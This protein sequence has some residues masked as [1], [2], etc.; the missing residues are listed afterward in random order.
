MKKRILS[1]VLSFALVF[2]LIPCSMA[3]AASQAPTDAQLEEIFVDMGFAS[4]VSGGK[5]FSKTE[6]VSPSAAFW[7]LCLNG[8]MEKYFDEDTWCYELTISQYLK[9]MDQAFVNY[10][11]AEVKAY[12][13]EHGYYNPADGN[14][15]SIFA[16][17]MGDVWAWEP[18]SI[19]KSGDTYTIKGLFLY[20]NE[21]TGDV[22]DDDKRYY[23]YWKYTSE[24][25][26]ENGKPQS[27]TSKMVIEESLSVTVENT[28]DGLK[29]SSYQV[30][31]YYTYNGKTY[32][33]NGNTG[34]FDLSVSL[35]YTKMTYTGNSITPTVVAAD[36]NGNEKSNY[37][38]SYSK[39]TI[40]A[41]G[42]YYVKVTPKAP[43]DGS[44]KL[45]FTIVPK[46]P[47]KAT[48][49]LYGYDD[50]K[51]TWSK[52]TGATGYTVYYKKSGD[53]SYTYL[54]RTTGTSVKKSGLTDGKKYYFKVVPYYTN[55]GTRYA[56]TKYKT[57]SVYTLKKV[58]KPTVTTSGTKVKV[59]WTGIS[60]ETGYQIYKMTKS[61][62]KYTK[63]ASY[64][65]TGT[66]KTI[67]ATKGKTYYYKVRA[68]K[69]VGDEKIYAPWSAIVKYKR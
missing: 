24:Y 10:D 51:F 48:A 53:D 8:R 4:Q 35:K 60:G 42:R 29:V 44:V 39:D 2:S 22:T 37:T 14:H 17:G 34:R 30:L 67:T 64:T 12:L 15:V 38:V 7:F 31:P 28:E 27:Y 43:Y 63:V 19:S 9:L 62:G 66:Y 59:K 26:D 58:S 6:D 20:G 18:L 68:Y 46:A 57:A 65:T 40:K 16:G 41:V 1:L 25:L 69:T 52:S 32:F 47:S 5:E 61:D 13:Q 49:E 50:I 11:E 33:Q 45:Y 21:E 36:K 23:D 54:K 55:N 56:S 3:F